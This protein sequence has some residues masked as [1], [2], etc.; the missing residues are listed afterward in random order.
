MTRDRET[1]EG[2]LVWAAAR[3]EWAETGQPVSVGSVAARSG[4][5]HDTV[6]RWLTEAEGEEFEVAES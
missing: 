1:A 4:I 3:E 5:D 2:E 6:R